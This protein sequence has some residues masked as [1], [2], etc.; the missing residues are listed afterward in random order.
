[1]N[2][3]RSFPFILLIILVLILSAGGRSASAGE[4]V[5]GEPGDLPESPRLDRRLAQR[6]QAPAGGV[7]LTASI[8]ESPN[9]T[10]GPDWY[11]YTWD[12]S[13]PLNWIDAASGGTDVGLGPEDYYDISAPIS[14]PFPFRFYEEV[15][16]EV[17]VAPYGY[18]TFIDDYYVNEQQNPFPDISRPNNLVAPFWTII[19]LAN[20]GPDGRVYYQ[21]GGTAPNR[22]F[23]VEWH[24]VA[25]GEPSDPS[26]DDELYRFE[27]VL[28]ENG[29]ILFQYHTM[30]YNDWRYYASAGIEDQYGEGTGYMDWS[31]YQEIPSGEA[32]LFHYPAPAARVNVTPNYFGSFT[33]AG[34][35]NEFDIPI[36]NTG[37]LG[38]DTYD[39][40]VS[41]SWPA[42]LFAADGMTPL[43]DS[44]TDGAVDTGSVSQGA[45]SHVVVK[46][47][48][49]SGAIV[50][51]SNITTL[52]VNSSLNPAKMKN[53]SL[54]S[55]IPTAFTQ[56]YRDSDDDYVSLYLAQPGGQAV[57]Q[58]SAEDVYSG[59]QAIAE[60][61][62][63]NFL[64]VWNAYRSL[65]GGA[66]S[67]GVMEIYYV[68]LNRYG[69][70]VHAPTKLAD[71]SGV[72]YSTYDYEP[73]IA[74]TPD[75]HMGVFW[76]R[77]QY[78]SATDGFNYNLYLTTLDANGAWVSGP[79]SVTN[80]A[81]WGT[82]SDANIPRYWSPRIA[83]TTDNRFVLSWRKYLYASNNSL[84][85][86]E[87]AVY[88]A[89][90]KVV[91][92]PAQLTNSAQ[93]GQDYYYPNL[94]SLTNDRV[95]LLYEGDSLFYAI[96]DSSGSLVKTE[97]TLT[98]YGYDS[99]AVQLAGGNILVAWSYWANLPQTQYALLSGS[100]YDLVYGPNTLSNPAALAGDDY[101]SVTRD[102]AGRGVLTWMDSGWGFEHN[103]YYA[104]IDAN[105]SVLT[106]PVIFRSSQQGLYDYIVSSYNGYGNSTYSWTPPG[107]DLSLSTGEAL[108]G[109]Q[110]GGGAPVGITY[111]NHGGGEASGVVITATL[112][113]SLTYL[114]DSSGV[115]PTA[116]GNQ[117]VWQMPD[118]SF[119]ET[120]RF[121]LYV[122]VPANAALGDRFPVQVQA[123]CTGSDATPADNSDSLEI[124]VSRQVYL[125]ILSR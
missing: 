112:G 72:Q 57:K 104:L 93:S 114:S 77:Y 37:E 65:S 38:A 96:L 19:A 69:D 58:A 45:T 70:V 8:P 78:D 4:E 15:Y 9:A 84:N 14:L 1:M 124:M 52:S 22:Y 34:A 120:R 11:G 118:L 54:A 12:D 92:S 13:V 47:G 25:G 29:D 76:Y 39:I 95:I 103:L 86:I 81:V 18:L 74:V 51:N 26:G 83:A 44:D 31:P 105:G 59:D 20:S 90:G 106:Q 42:Q 16:T 115:A 35:Q 117:L 80:N 116:A 107:V 79:T 23:V 73:V 100:S 91:K 64:V 122:G 60:A 66:N 119:L 56:I 85:D 111:A 110:A 36:R 71:L 97:T 6:Q 101:V 123:S 27:A 75:G 40:N 89:D 50:G 102:A 63:G 41:S 21:S 46:V 108:S 43:S 62:N 98:D 82:W 32:I 28:Y 55:T 2:H 24:N 88:S 87:Y 30:I 68:L 67:I 121:M 48:V 109:G 61:P 7:P 3:V 33:H 17:W 49:P 5:P 125:P 113:I 99:D 94:A 53:V 10:G